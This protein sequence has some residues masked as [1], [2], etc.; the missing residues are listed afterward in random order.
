MDAVV[1]GAGV[2]SGDA[3]GDV[4]AAVQGAC[5]VLGEEAE[6]HGGVVSGAGAVVDGVL[7]GDGEAGGGGGGGARQVPQAGGFAE[8]VECAD[9][10]RLDQGRVPNVPSAPPSS[11]ATAWTRTAV[12]RPTAG[13]RSAAARTPA[14]RATAGPLA[15][16]AP[17]PVKRRPSKETGWAPATVSRWTLNITVRSRGSSGPRRSSRLGWSSRNAGSA[18]TAART[19]TGTS[20]RSTASGGGAVWPTTSMPHRLAA[21]A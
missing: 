13:H 12:S 14:S 18:V 7:A 10:A 21:S 3:G 20:S 15:S 2:Q 4:G 6:E 9:V 11:P 17:R 8:D 19:R 1:G 16:T 5:E